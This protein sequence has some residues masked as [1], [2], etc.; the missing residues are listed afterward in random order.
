MA[1]AESGE[2]LGLALADERGGIQ[3][4]H[5]LQAVADDFAAGGRGQF[6]EFGERIARIRMVAGFEFDADEENPFGPCVSG[7]DERFQRVP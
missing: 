6:T 2:F 4:F 7:F 5:F 1:P 3:R